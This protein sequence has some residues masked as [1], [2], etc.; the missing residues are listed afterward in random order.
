MAQVHLFSPLKLRDIEFKNRIFVSPMC[1]YSATEGFPNEWHL[2]H[3]GSRAVGGAGLVMVEATAVRP[4]GRISLGDLGLWNEEHAAKFIPIVNFIK[5]QGAVPGI[6]LAHAGRKASASV[7]WK[8]SKPLSKEDGAWQTVG[9]SALPFSEGWPTPREMSQKEITQLVADFT[10]SAELAYRAGF[11]VIELHMAHGYLLN[12]FLSPLSNQ[13]TDSYG[14]SLE[15]RM[16]LPLEVVDAIRKVWPTGLPLF[17][18]ISATEWVENGWDLA[19]SIHFTKEL[20]KHGVDLI[21]CS[22]GGNVPGVKIPLE[23]G[24]QVPLAEGVRN[25]ANIPTG[26]VG[27]ITDPLKAEEILASGKADAIFLARELLRHPY[28]PLHAAKKL[29]VDVPWPLQYERAK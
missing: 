21:D 15:N 13:R 14:G 27:L 17:V 1:M 11:Q 6:Q 24:Y 26:A 4:E 16:R 7:G 3:L 29:G 20:K 8:G 18:R 25:G 2:V 22:T 10:H 9:P 19:Q 28:W 12:E 23:P 5:A